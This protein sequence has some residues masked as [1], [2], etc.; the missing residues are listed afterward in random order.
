MA[1]NKQASQYFMQLYKDV[2]SQYDAQALAKYYDKQLMAYT[3]DFEFCY[4]QFHQLLNFNHQNLAYMQPEFHRIIANGDK[5][6][7]AWFT[8]N[9]YD[10]QQK[11]VLSINTM[12]HYVIDDDKVKQ[13]NFMWDQPVAKVM[14]YSSEILGGLTNML[15]EPLREL[16]LREL[17]LRELECFFHLIQSKTAKT[18]AKELNRSARTIESHISNIKQKLNLENVRDI[19]EY[20]YEH[21]LI[22]LSPLFEQLYTAEINHDTQKN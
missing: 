11:L 19:V 7:L 4:E 12:S 5:S 3:A 6:L 13:I 10:H 9:H 16:S 2:W 20:A 22:T 15:P 17:S 14:G 18:I 1:D 21:Q 8:T